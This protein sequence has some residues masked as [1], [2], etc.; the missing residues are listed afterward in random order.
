MFIPGSYLTGK[1]E[2]VKGIGPAKAGLLQNELGIYLIEDL[3]LDFPIRYLDRTKITPIAEAKSEGEYVQVKGILKDFRVM[4]QGRGRRL[5]ALVSDDTGGMELVWF[6]SIEWMVNHLTRGMEY[7]VNGRVSRFRNQYNMAHPEMEAAS[8]KKTDSFQTFIPV[9]RS[10]E[11][12]TKRGLDTKGRNRIMK[13]LIAELPRDAFKEYLPDEL[14]QKF[15]FADIYETTR[16]IHY[17][18]NQKQ[19]RIAE[20]RI[21]FEEFFFVQL[22]L[23]KQY[24]T[25][26]RDLKGHVFETVGDYFMTFYEEHLPFELTGAQKRV[27]REIR[28]D[29][30]TGKQM[31]RLL[32]G[33][34]GSGKT[35]VA[36]L[37]ALLARDNG[38]QTALLAPTEILA[39]QHFESLTQLTEG[40]KYQVAILT[41]K[42][43]TAERKELLRML[44]IGAIDLLVGTHALLEDRVQ[45]EEIGLAIIDEQHR[46]GVAQ[47]AKLWKKGKRLPPHVLVMSATPIPRT[48]HMTT[49]GDLDVS[50]IDELP[51]GRKPIRTLHKTEFY[52]SDVI[53]FM[54]QEIAKGR[55]IYVVYPLIEESESLDLE[56]LNNG[57]EKLLTFFPRPDYQ[58]G[59]VHGR[60]TPDEKEKEMERFSRGTTHILVSTTVIEVGVNI[61]NAAVMVIEN[62]NRFGLA[63]LHQLRGRVGRGSYQSYCILMTGNKLGDDAR[64]RIDTMVRTNDGFEI[65]EVDLALRGP[66]KVQGTEQSGR[67]NFRKAD[68]I[69]HKHILKAARET[70]KIILEEDPDLE[71]DKHRGIKAYLEARHKSAEWWGRIS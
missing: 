36:L 17:P 43:K 64:T 11:K 61:P 63:Q 52:R 37:A 4:G 5:V 23:I 59:V 21:I 33:D 66:G 15:R 16:M 50:V 10:T 24:L 44:R 18:M 62:A 3:L 57:Y 51:P 13:P 71:S 7:V 28:R 39:Q 40:M 19:L 12:L 70:A 38:F 9:Y 2:F 49:Y 1:I 45:F 47:R 68:L 6:K 29:M 14:R 34:V 55:Q 46:F 67:L 27:L 20:N 48:L 56:D 41:G 69:E 22:R 30:G 8:K 26:K 25:R 35:I 32:Q 53:K 31:N 58:I 42:T 54:K 60:M 65:A